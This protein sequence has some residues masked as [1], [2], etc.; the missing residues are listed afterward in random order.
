MNNY[1][2]DGVLTTKDLSL[3]TEK[4]LKKGVAVIECIQEIPCNPCVD[5]CP[6]GAI[7]MKD[8]N[9]APIVDYDKCIA[10]GK[11]VG[12]CP[13]LAIF[14]IKIKDGKALI[15]IPYEFLPIPKK[16]ENVKAL[17]RMGEIVSDATVKKIIKKGKTMIVTVEVEK[18]LW[19]EVRNI[20]VE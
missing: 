15:T 14:V 12:V 19:N 8:I 3:P 7:S 5:S 2:K 20:K 9:A 17:N 11:C 10:C 4:Q 16:E 1:E 13:G 6:V 18:N